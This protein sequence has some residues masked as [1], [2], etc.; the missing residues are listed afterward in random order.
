MAHIYIPQP[1]GDLAVEVF[2]EVVLLGLKSLP[3]ALSVATSPH[4]HL[5]YNTLGAICQ[6]FF[7]KF[8][9]KSR[10][11]PPLNYFCGCWC[12]FKGIARLATD[13]A[14]RSISLTPGLFLLLRPVEYHGLRFVRI[15]SPF[16]LSQ[17][18]IGSKSVGIARPSPLEHL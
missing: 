8:Y 2:S 6:G 15:A 7:E 10:N 3:I 16:L 12:G 1:R 11:A 17:V 14:F 5:Y 13:L 4:L 9:D 18:G